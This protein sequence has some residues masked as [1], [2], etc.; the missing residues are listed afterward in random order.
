L[1]AF[2]TD[3][4]ISPEGK[5]MV[6]RGQPITAESLKQQ[7]EKIE[8]DR[9]PNTGT[10]SK[11]RKKKKRPPSIPVNFR[12]YTKDPD[13]KYTSG[14]T[15]PEGQTFYRD[16]PRAY[17][18]TPAM[19][20]LG[21][22]K[23]LDQVPDKTDGGQNLGQVRTLVQQVGPKFLPQMRSFRDNDADR[24]L[25]STH[26]KVF[27]ANFEQ[28]REAYQQKRSINSAFT[29]NFT[30]ENLYEYFFDNH[31][32]NGELVCLL[33]RAAYYMNDQTGTENILLSRLART[34]NTT[35]FNDLRNDMAQAL[36]FTYL[37]AK[38][39]DETYEMYQTYH[40]GTDPT[41][42]SLIMV[43]PTMA[44][45]MNALGD[46]TNETSTEADVPTIAIAIQTYAD[47]IRGLIDNISFG[48]TGSQDSTFNPITRI[49]WN[50]IS[51]GQP[52][53][54]AASPY[55]SYIFPSDREWL[56]Q[57]QRK[58]ING[59]MADV[60]LNC[61]LRQLNNIPQGNSTA[62]YNSTFSDMFNN[63]HLM[64]KNNRWYPNVILGGM[65][66][67]GTK[68]VSPL[69]TQ[70]TVYAS[71]LPSDSIEY[72]GIQFMMSRFTG[73]DPLYFTIRAAVNE[74]ELKYSR[75]YLQE[76]SRRVNLTP[77][78]DV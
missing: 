43:T 73:Y 64:H 74:G 29:D 36:R 19:G 46:A 17:T 20:K 53:Y 51:G 40:M 33:Q 8:R 67:A 52:A 15:Q 57:S 68:Q 18:S 60:S 66:S 38:L 22:I 23:N 6:V 1:F 62:E 54:D 42:G 14:D 49:W 47:R 44:E 45:L 4:A 34:L 71:E 2:K 37:P 48:R 70:N 78:H 28:Y 65:D 9:K 11:K 27:A 3:G 16:G 69:H 31:A 21:T 50:N 61:N 59:F 5:Q 63:T 10:K 26:A 56:T 41:A 12:P 76:R 39:I 55:T 35:T 72:K 77:Q 7:A 13:M 58:T 30:E 75:F 24:K 32:L 25:D